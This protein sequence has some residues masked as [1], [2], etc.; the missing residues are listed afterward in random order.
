MPIIF[1]SDFLSGEPRPLALY[2][3][4]PV[5]VEMAP[6]AVNNVQTA[7]SAGGPGVAWWPDGNH[8]T[9][10]LAGWLNL[11]SVW[12][13]TSMV[14]PLGRVGNIPAADL[15]DAVVRL[16]CRAVAGPGYQYGFYLPR[17]TRLGWWIQTYDPAACNG[18]GG[19]ANW[20][21]TRNL[22]CEQMGV[23]RPYVRNGNDA[24]IMASKGWVDCVIPLSTDPG[25]WMAMGCN[26]GKATT[27]GNSSI[28][29]ALKTWSHD[30]GIIAV[31]GEHGASYPAYTYPLG[32]G[33]GEFHIDSIS[34][35]TP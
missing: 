2:N 26:P 8:T 7:A 34:I 22:I 12:Y 19:Y 15:R 30:M 29:Y 24:V 5:Y 9:P 31:T 10:G 6:R 23:N 33:G 3:Q 17:S 11:V 14:D 21:Q 27:Y 35:E 20:F 13:A 18:L 1:S 25:D 4:N 16:R 28:G 32:F